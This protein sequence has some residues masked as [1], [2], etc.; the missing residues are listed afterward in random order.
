MNERGDDDLCPRYSGVHK[1]G[2]VAYLFKEKSL[3]HVIYQDQ[4]LLFL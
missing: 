2:D 4:D 3:I 1:K